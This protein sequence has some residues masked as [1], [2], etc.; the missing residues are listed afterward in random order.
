MALSAKAGQTAYICLNEKFSQPR[1]R[2]ILILGIQRNW[3]QLLVRAKNQEEI[4]EGTGRV[5]VRDFAFF[6]IQCPLSDLR[7]GC[8]NTFLKLEVDHSVLLGE[9]KGLIDSD[10]ELQFATASDADPG[11]M[12]R[13]TRKKS[14]RQTLESGSNSDS[15]EEDM[16]GLLQQMQ[17]NWLGGDTSKGRSSRD[18]ERRSSTKRFALLEKGRKEKEQKPSATDPTAQLL[19][20]IDMEDPLKALVTL[21][22]AQQLKASQKEKRKHR[23]HSS[24]QSSSHRDHSSSSS[25]RSSN[26]RHSS[27]AKAIEN[28]R[29][30]KKRMFRKSLKHVRRYVK[31]VERHLGAADRPFKLS[32]LGKKISWGPHKS[33]QRVHYMMSEVLEEMLK[34]RMERACLMQVLCLRSVHQC[35]IDRGDWEVAWLVTH[36]DNPFTRPKWGGDEAELGN[37]AAYLKSMA[38]LERSTSKLRGSASQVEKSEDQGKPWPKKGK[39]GKGRGKNDKNEKEEET[40]K[41]T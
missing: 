1:W 18:V 2:E 5:D 28:Y 25:S 15:S 30:A 11:Q 23:S 8:S 16:T 38:E 17:K 10:P 34:G 27:H 3:A 35:C 40:G 22:L 32:E 20:N 14:G 26:R 41:E 6:L 31:E 9:G 21:Q 39:K 24:S 7:V 37:V 12:A 19:Q 4:P 13:T 36:L 33:L 29:D